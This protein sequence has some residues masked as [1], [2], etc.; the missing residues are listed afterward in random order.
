MAENDQE[1]GSKR[2]LPAR[3]RAPLLITLLVIGVVGASYYAYYRKQSDY[4]TGRNLRLLSMLTAQIEGRVAMYSG[5]VSTRGSAFRGME[6]LSCGPPNGSDNVVRREIQESAKGWNILLQAKQDQCAAISL[7]SLLRP[8]FARRIGAAFDILVVAK[9]DGTVLY[10]TRQAPNTS[11]LLHQE[12]EWI[13]EEEEEP[14]AGEP[15]E[16]EIAAADTSA[17]TAAA[18]RESGS[19]VLIARLQALSKRKGWREYEPLKPATLVDATGQTDVMLGNGSYVLFSQPYTFASA[20][21]TVGQKP[22]RW[23]VCGL[24]SASRFHYDVSA[25]STTLILIAVAI[26]ALALCCWPFLRIALI[27]PRQALTIADVVLVVICTIVGAAVVTLALLD[28]FT[29]RNM[30]AIA[31]TQ[32]EAYSKKLHDDFLGNVRRGVDLLAA[33]EKATQVRATDIVSHGGQ[34][35]GELLTTDLLTDDAIKAYPYIHS[36]QWIDGSGMQIVRFDRIRS[37]LQ[38]VRD[39]Q[40]FQLAMKE[41]PWSADGKDYILEWVRSKSTGEVW[42]MMAKKTDVPSFAVVAVATELIDITH[43]VAPPGVE[44]AIIDETGE[45]LYH[46]D[47]QRI[48]YENF[49]AEADRNRELRSA[50]VARR[51][52]S[53][54]AK[55]WG[56]DQSMYVRPLTGSGWTLVTFRPKR[57]TRVLNVEGALLTLALLLMSALPSFLVYILVLLF[58]PRYRAPRLWPDVARTEDYARLNLILVSLLLLF[59]M[60]IYALAPWSSFYEILI[61]PNLA[62]LTVYLILH[63]TGAERRYRIA[64]A[65]WIALNAVL[66]AHLILADV[67]PTH[68]VGEYPGTVLG[69][70]ILSALG[71]AL[72]TYH[73]LSPQSGKRMAKAPRAISFTIGYSRLYR[74]C[75]VLL[76]VV[77]VAMPVV[78]FFAISRRVETQLL[79]K[80]AQL[81]AAADLEHRIDHLE[82]LNALPAKT[83]APEV[84]R[85]VLCL[86]LGFILESRWG[87]RPAV[88]RPLPCAEA[89]GRPKEHSLDKRRA[90]AETLPPA[91]A[92]SLPVLYE[93]S[94]AV[95]PLFG[96]QSADGF[97]SW[98][99][100]DGRLLLIRKIRFDVDV[101]DML[102][103][104]ER[105]QQGTQESIVIES[106]V[107][108]VASRDSWAYLAVGLLIALPLLAVFWFASTFVAKRVLLIGV[109][110]PDWLAPL[111]I[112]PTLGESIFLVRRNVDPTGLTGDD[113]KGHG[114]PFFSVSFEN[115]HEMKRWD[116]VLQAVES[117]KPGRNV[118]ILDFEYGIDDPEI[119]GKKLQWLERLVALPDRRAIIVS[120]VTP[121]YM[122]T[123]APLPSP[124]GSPSYFD[125][126]RAVFDHFLCVAAEELLRRDSE[127][128]R[129]QQFLTI[130]QLNAYQP[131]SWRERETTYDPFLQQLAKEIE[132]EAKDREAALLD[133][134]TEREHLLDEIG[135]RAE[136]YYAGLWSSCR[137][138]EKLQLDQLA[139]HGLANGRNRRMLRRLMARGLVRRDP[140]L[141]LF[142]ETFRSTYWP[143]RSARTSSA[144]HVRRMLP[145]PG[146]RC[147]SHSS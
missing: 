127:W 86:P 137:E 147:A 50:V 126:W 93:D 6:P 1:G 47:V 107:P 139:N 30:T 129:Q 91:M 25:V 62:I 24:V 70:L 29:Y 136:A 128:K 140:N 33:A 17:Q 60:D 35:K 2:F 100:D 4:F 145:V 120:T 14:H 96:S 78:G 103:K 40:Y 80:Y 113:P 118:R 69:V 44:L 19:T 125:R 46:S 49:F 117:S 121:A 39:R 74:L 9:D 8:V 56:E 28:G 51:A 114:L 133:T 54:D 3:A 79:V 98:L 16:P 143:P 95:R 57:L 71:V 72:F 84:D 75:G 88:S 110:E 67:D 115:L 53:V 123:T 102:W 32:L 130:S 94:L 142:S 99:G 111:P 22:R 90:A 34:T 83:P 104:D 132:S 144:A 81:R 63:R 55:Y 138:D 101:A 135:E 73:L 77:G 109:N 65:L 13:D 58:F 141:R 92:A 146:T 10:T 27:D 37:P 66:I 20:A 131:K 68:G 41:R 122:M 116:E 12:E 105:P 108:H 59:W 119:N 7:D 18:E 23:I 76:L 89:S 106:V 21:L 5:F 11:T 52:G 15:K 38:H 43:T 45:V 26:V 31:D 42:A 97:W 36:I 64:T 87:L 112:C 61:L 82:T 48:G 85:D 124:E 134:T